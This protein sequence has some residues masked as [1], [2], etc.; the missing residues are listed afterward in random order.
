MTAIARACATGRIA[1]RINRVVSDREAASGIALAQQLGLATAVIARARFPDQDAFEAALAAEFEAA[2]AELVVLAGFMRVL[3]A[4]FVAS[5]AGRIINI[6][7][8]LLPLHRGLHTHRRALAGGEREHGASVHFVTDELDGGPIIIRARVPIL[9]GD[10][11]ETL[12]ARVQRQEHRIYP[13]AI[14]LIADGRLSVRGSTILLDGLPLAAPLEEA[15]A[16]APLS[17]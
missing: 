9:P 10:T 4:D 7:P 6:H 2:G 3:S 15:E 11:E 13:R 8:S 1:A 12:S 5:Y 14:G 17:A 16:D